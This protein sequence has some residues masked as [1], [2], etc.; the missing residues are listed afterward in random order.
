MVRS[1]KELDVYKGAIEAAETQVW[2]ELSF[3]CGYIDEKTYRRLDDLYDHII[4]Q[5]VRMIED[6]ERWTM[7]I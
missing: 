2:V 7:H 4:G 1:Y 6:A 5:I 3:C